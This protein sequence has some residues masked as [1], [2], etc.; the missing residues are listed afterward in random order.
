MQD[1][2]AESQA[3]TAVFGTCCA[4][5]MKKQSRAG[6]SRSRAHVLGGAARRGICLHHKRAGQRV[7]ISFGEGKRCNRGDE[8]GCTSRRQRTSVSWHQVHSLRLA[9]LYAVGLFFA[10]E[11]CRFDGAFRGKADLQVHCQTLGGGYAIVYTFHYPPETSQHLYLLVLSA[12]C[13]GELL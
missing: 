9:G 11:Y 12:C 7:L 10:V 13:Q 1:A 3:G 4:L 8:P 5:K 6:P 2:N